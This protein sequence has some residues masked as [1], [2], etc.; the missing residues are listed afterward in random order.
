MQTRFVGEYRHKENRVRG[1]SG[2]GGGPAE[3][4]VLGK[5]SRARCTEGQGRW[6][7]RAVRRDGAP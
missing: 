2:G 3:T 6:L 1:F 5:E 7:G 4:V